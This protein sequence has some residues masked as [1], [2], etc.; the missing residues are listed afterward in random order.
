MNFEHIEA[1]R[2]LIDYARTSNDKELIEAA[3]KL[4]EYLDG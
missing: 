4:E 2:L 3:K 1:A